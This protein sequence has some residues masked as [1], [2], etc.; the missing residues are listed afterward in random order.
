M[1]IA[2]APASRHRT[3]QE[4]VYRTLREAIIRCELR[5]G[6][7]L[8]IDELA[9]RLQV[10]IIP[11]REALQTLQAEA[12]VVSV[13]HVGT[14][15]APVSR[16]AILDVFSVLEGLETVATRLVAERARP[17]ELQT[18]ETLVA[19]MDD[20]VAE[21]RHEAWAELNRK[22]HLAIGDLPGLDLLSELTGRVLDRWERVRRYF[23]KGVLVHRV[24][25]AQ[26]EHRALLAAMK[27]RDRARLLEL[28]RQHNQLALAAYLAYLDTPGSQVG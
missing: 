10:S 21:G 7:R 20:A 6:E 22:F 8:I 15:V 9:R 27:A 11:V 4:F 5:P 13:P 3:K 23:F 12:L 2:A 16:E 25:Q 28:V 1:P 26:E 17:E 14:T 18:L 24:A 19:A